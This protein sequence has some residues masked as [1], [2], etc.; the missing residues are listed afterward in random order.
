MIRRCTPRFG[1]LALVALVGAT[2]SCAPPVKT[3]DKGDQAHR[4][5]QAQHDH[6]H[7]APATTRPSRAGGKSFDSQE[8]GGHDPD[9]NAG[10]FSAW[11][12]ADPKVKDRFTS[13]YK[14]AVDDRAVY[15][16]YL[17]ILGADALLDYLE[18]ENPLC[19]GVAHSLGA[20]LYAQSKDLPESLQRCAHRCTGACMHG[21]VGEAFGALN[22]RE[23]TDKME[24]VC[25]SGEMARLHKPG[26]CAHATGH[27]LMLSSNADLG[28][29]L[30]AC[31]QFKQPGM[32]YYCATGV[33]MQYEMFLDEG[34]G[35]RDRQTLYSPCDKYTQ[36]PAACYRY[37]VELMSQALNDDHSKLTKACMALPRFERLGCFHGLGKKYSRKIG[38]TSELLAQVCLIGNAEDQAMCIEGAIEKLADHNEQLARRACATLT[39]DGLRICQAAAAEKMYRL[40]KP[41]MPL[42][43]PN[44]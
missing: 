35:K 33:F 29:S 20:E 18:K 22:P 19:H 32:D 23:I 41:T 3:E 43:R 15:K 38:Q 1:R 5:E 25:Q 17:P 40:N 42:Y 12:S 14:S 44:G 13:D 28:W 30:D 10:R 2:V 8:M 7:H 34:K 26:N 9:Q 27:A 6:Q 37:I 21:V 16:K 36:F 11:D 4:H 39:G 24:Q 31:R